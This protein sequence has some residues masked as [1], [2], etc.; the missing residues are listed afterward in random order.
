MPNEY[1]Q[2]ERSFH[3]SKSWAQPV[4]WFTLS[5]KVFDNLSLSLVIHFCKMA[6]CKQ[7]MKKLEI[8]D[9]EKKN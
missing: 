8:M 2:K 3:E 6:K 7:E 4:I 9:M 5:L 1:G